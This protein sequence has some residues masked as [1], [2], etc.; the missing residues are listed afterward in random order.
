MR[1]LT[2]LGQ[3][4]GTDKATYHYFTEVYDDIFSLYK[5]PRILEIGVANYA[6]IATYLDYFENPYIVGMD[7]FDK[8]V[9]VN[10][11][12]KFIQGDQSNI[13]DLSR[14]VDGEELFD[15]V[16][17]DGGHMMKQQQISFGYLIN[18]IKPGG[19]YI[20]EDLHTSFRVD[21]RDADCQFTSYEM[22]K[23]IENNILPFSNYVPADYQKS[24]L[25]KIDTINIFAKDPNNL[26]DSVTSIIKLR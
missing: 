12:W 13:D 11:K 14:C 21:Y 3:R 15:I 20:L 7:I 17:E 4:H 26:Q 5:N 24:I 25:E 1:K 16:I 19:Y 10:D 8:S 2:T 9:Y 23:N 18:Y 6:S 22:L